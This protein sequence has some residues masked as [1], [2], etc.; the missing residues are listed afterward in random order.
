MKDRDALV[1]LVLLV[2]ATRKASSSSPGVDQR[3]LVPGVYWWCASASEAQPLIAWFTGNASKV[4][5]ARMLGSNGA[6]CAVVLFSVF[7]GITWPLSGTPE[8]APNG[9]DTTLD[10][11]RGE[12]H[13]AEFFRRMAERTWEQIKA[14]DARVQQWLQSVLP[15]PP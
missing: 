6:D 15:A 1:L 14:F 10:D 9:I 5:L 3:W 7:E 4:H 12:S 13:L 2:L 11:L 8:E